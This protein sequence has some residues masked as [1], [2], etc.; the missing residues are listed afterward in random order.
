M[1][2][3]QQ[4]LSD[5]LLLE[6]SWLEASRIALKARSSDDYL[7]LAFAENAKPDDLIEVIRQFYL[8]VNKGI[9]P[10][11][12]LLKVVANGFEKYVLANGELSLDE[13]F[14]KKRKGKK[15]P[16][17]QKLKDENRWRIYYFMWCQIKLSELDNKELSILA[18][19]G[20]AR[21]KFLRH[22]SIDTLEKE[23]ITSKVS[24]KYNQAFDVMTEHVPDKKLEMLTWNQLKV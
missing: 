20:M 2:K 18:A 7:Q 10:P 15:H 11:A 4:S 3:P 12:S 14:I 13:S 24:E 17:K 1:D 19:A 8:C 5:F 21:D 9:T 23:Y 16:I 6:Q 22:I